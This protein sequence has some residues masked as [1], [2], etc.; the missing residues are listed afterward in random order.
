[1][2]DVVIVGAGPGG[3]SAAIYAARYN[4]KT[5]VIGTEFGGTIIEAPSVENY[6]GFKKIS[7]LELMEKFKE[8]AKN[9]KAEIKEE[10]VKA[11]RKGKEHFIVTTSKNEYE[12]KTLVLAL[13]TRRRKLNVPREERF[14]GKGVSYC[15]TC[16]APFYRDKTVAVIGGSDSAAQA[17]LIASEYAKKVFI[18]YRKEELR[19]EPINKERVHKNEKIEVIYNANVIEMSG[20]NFLESVKLDT[21][22][23]LR[24]D[25]L[26][27][28][29]GLVPS[30][31]LAAGLGA[32]LNE[33]GEIIINRKS[34]TNVPGVF[35]AGDVTD[36]FLKQAIT[37]SA[38]GCTAALSAYLYIKSQ[39]KK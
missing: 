1:M 35:A 25:G 28:E 14:I 32:K 33:K 39:S 12:A 24:V 15:V 18:I 10:E 36:G 23:E 27:V 17:A 19:A 34:E 7:G 20:R 31:A 22:R 21:G 2:Y 13:G 37:A 11:I 6:P 8:H 29:I 3:L 4:L 30:G 38:E 5:L 26:F 16:D 9:L